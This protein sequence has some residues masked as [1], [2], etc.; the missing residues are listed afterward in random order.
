[1][2]SRTLVVEHKTTSSDIGPGSRY[3]R[4][5]TL[6]TQISQY[7]RGA[8]ELPFATPEGMLYDVI[9]K[10]R[11]SPLLATPEE[12]RK[13]TKPS[14]KEPEPRLYAN[15][16]D[17][18][19]TPAEYYERLLED[20]GSEP[21]AYYQRGIIVRVGDEAR[22]AAHDT[23]LVAGSIRESRTA[24]AWPRNPGSCESYGQL[25]PYWRVCAEGANIADETLYRTAETAH[26]ELPELKHKLPLLSNSAMSTYRACPRRYYY[27]YELLRRPHTVYAALSF[28]TLAAIR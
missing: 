23:W 10:P 11:I 16:R 5:L 27:A 6:D 22:A 18:D 21:D 3:W 20:I 14:K 17:R 9:R 4:R 2:P 8:T 13:Y 19:E 1:M 12:S 26:E 28:G 25:C 15:Q 7:M 24:D